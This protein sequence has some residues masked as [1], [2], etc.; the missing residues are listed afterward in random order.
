MFEARTGFHQP[1]TQQHVYALIAK[2]LWP[3]F[4]I[5]VYREP[6]A[7][8]YVIL[9]SH[10]IHLFTLAVRPSSCERIHYEDPPIELWSPYEPLQASYVGHNFLL[11]IYELL[12]RTFDS[13]DEIH[14]VHPKGV[15]LHLLVW[16]T[17]SQGLHVLYVLPSNNPEPRDTIRSRELYHS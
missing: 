5:F 1:S 4:L 13:F 8:M 9:A 12:K 11:K 2:P 6:P 16:I 17:D 10:S 3:L 7:Q 14:S 15:I